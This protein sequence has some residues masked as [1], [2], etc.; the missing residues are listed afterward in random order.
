MYASE[1]K[2]AEIYIYDARDNESYRIRVLFNPAEYSISRSANYA[3]K[4][5]VGKDNEVSQ[6]TSGTSAELRMSLYFDGH[7]NMKPGGQ[8]ED[9]T[10]R[11]E[12]FVELLK[13]EGELHKPPKC[14][15]AWGSLEFIG[16]VTSLETSYTMFDPSGKPLRAKMDITFKRAVNFAAD[17]KAVSLYSP[18]RSKS[19]VLNQDVQLYELAWE[20]YGDCGEWREIAAANHIANPR[21]LERGQ[22]L[23]VP[24]L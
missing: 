18:D 13:V 5:P 11:M 15:V 7:V 19:R 8:P 1:L 14:R 9:I 10:L 24:A 20:E 2:K 21:K 17:G 22:T 4:K 6:F 3:D 23:R 12:E 16:V